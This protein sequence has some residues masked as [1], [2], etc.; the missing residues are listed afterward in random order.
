MEG[1]HTSSLRLNFGL[2]KETWIKSERKI[3]GPK[4]S[5]E[6]AGRLVDF[7]GGKDRR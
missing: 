4:R 1:R 7:I 5:R 6:G 3:K 2:G